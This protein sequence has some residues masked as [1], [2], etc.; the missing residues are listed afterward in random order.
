MTN[1]AKGLAVM[2]E[3]AGGI[4]AKGLNLMAEGLWSGL[5]ALKSGEEFG[6]IL[7]KML[8]STLQTIGQEATVRALMETAAGFAAL[9]TPATA[10]RT[11]R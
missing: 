2:G 4:A 3:Y 7:L 8:N 6:P 9:A 1:N 5:E 10:P 11:G